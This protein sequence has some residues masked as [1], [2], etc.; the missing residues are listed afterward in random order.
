MSRFKFR[1]NNK[2]IFASLIFAF[3]ILS[4]T[5]GYSYLHETLTVDGNTNVYKNNWNIHFKSDSFEVLDNKA[6][7]INEPTFTDNDTKLNFGINLD[8]PGNKYSFKVD[9]I[10]E[11]S[12]DGKL[13]DLSIEGLENTSNY[14]NYSITYDDGV[15][16]KKGDA[17]RFHG[18][19]TIKVY[20]EFKKDITPNDLLNNDTF[21]NLTLDLKYEQADGTEVDVA[22]VQNDLG[23]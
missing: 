11:G 12:I 22:H 4:G 17:L 14:L 18:K 2:L 6:L 7:I 5:V 19:E 1:K 9:V 13:S 20:I 8:K 16:I 10:N 21:L 15:E 23:N 3:F